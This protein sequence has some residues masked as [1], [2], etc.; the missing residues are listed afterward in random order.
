MQAMT[1]SPMRSIAPVRRKG[2]HNFHY[3][4]PEAALLVHVVRVGFPVGRSGEVAVHG[5]LTAAVG[6]A[7]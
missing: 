4:I 2:D 7:D 1:L 3:G 5:T 6:F